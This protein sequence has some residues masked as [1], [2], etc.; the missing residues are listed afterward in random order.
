MI[1]FPGALPPEPLAWP[2]IESI[3]RHLDLRATDTRQVGTLREV[4]L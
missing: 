2:V 3:I 4:P 1:D